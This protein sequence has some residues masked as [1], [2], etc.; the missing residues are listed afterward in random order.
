MKIDHQKIFQTEHQDDKLKIPWTLLKKRVQ[1]FFQIELKKHETSL[2]HMKMRDLQFEHYE[3]EFRHYAT[4]L[5][6]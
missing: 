2:A 5:C 6:Q 3:D 4:K 1:S